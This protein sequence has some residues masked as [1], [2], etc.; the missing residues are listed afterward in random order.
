MSEGQVF[1]P[2]VDHYWKSVVTL[3]QMAPFSSGEWLSWEP[4]AALK[5]AVGLGGSVPKRGSG[6]H[7]TASTDA[8]PT[9]WGYW[10]ISLKTQLKRRIVKSNTYINR[11]LYFNLKWINVCLFASLFNIEA[12]PF[13]QQELSGW[14]FTSFGKW[15]RRSLCKTSYFNT[16]ESLL[17]FLHMSFKA[18]FLVI[19]L[20][21]S[22]L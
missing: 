5:W 2:P 9:R 20:C 1:I 12:R 21:M 3:G 4:R 13:F 22:W 17:S 19:C 6:W 16:C 7:S 18:I 8:I 15:H 11:I 14:C 10:L